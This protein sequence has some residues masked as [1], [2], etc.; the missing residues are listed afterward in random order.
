[1]VDAVAAECEFFLLGER[2][3]GHVV[4][5]ADGEVVLGLGELEVFVDGN[6]LRG[7][8][9]VRAEAVATAH[10]EGCV[11][12]A[13][14]GFLDVEVEGFTVGTGLLGA[15]EHGDALGRLGHGCEEVLD[16]EGAVEVYAHEADLFALC[17]E[18][19]DGFACGFGSRAHEDDDAVGLVVA[20][21]VE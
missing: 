12:G 10:D 5:D 11:F 15:V 3:E 14:E 20:V 13:I 1:M 17:A 7:G 9:V 2:G 16:R 21:V 8:G 19:V 4:D 18:V 6:D